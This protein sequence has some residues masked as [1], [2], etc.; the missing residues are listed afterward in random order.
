MPHHGGRHN[1][2]P[3]ILNRLLGEK[4]EKGYCRRN[5]RAFVS[6]AEESDHPKQMVVNAFLRRGV[7]IFATKGRTV[8]HNY[9]MDSRDG[10]SAVEPEQ[11]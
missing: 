7:E 5:I 10:W 9:G 3:K 6:T 4:V 1:V 8:R 11:F 2:T